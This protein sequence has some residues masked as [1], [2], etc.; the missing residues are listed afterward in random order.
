VDGYGQPLP[1][2]VTDEKVRRP[3]GR[4]QVDFCRGQG[5]ESI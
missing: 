5:C 3:A 1:G 4:R 2:D